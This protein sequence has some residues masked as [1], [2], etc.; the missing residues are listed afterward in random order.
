MTSGDFFRG[1][2]VAVVGLG[3][4]GEMRPDIKFLLKLGITLTVYDMRGLPA[5]R[6]IIRDLKGRR[7]KGLSSR[8]RF[9]R[10]FDEP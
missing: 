7:T 10:S 3:P 2:K 6:R 1:K 4:R 8:R 5:L 9:C